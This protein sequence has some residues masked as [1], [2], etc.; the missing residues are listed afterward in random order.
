[1]THPIF[2]DGADDFLRVAI[3]AFILYAAMIGLVRL[4]GKRSVAQLNNFDWIMIVAMGSLMASAIM[5]DDVTLGET[6]VAVALMF[7]LQWVLTRMVYSAPLVSSLVKAEPRLLL[8]DGVLLHDALRRERV[9]E[10]EI[11]ATVR[12]AGIAALE[13]VKWVVLETDAQLSVIS[14]ES[15][16]GSPSSALVDIP[17]A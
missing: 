15:A 6:L 14:R 4:T 9:T 3:S 2:F 1:M 11:R 12:Q 13:D 16:E 7:A 17:G 8:K 10:A 5:L